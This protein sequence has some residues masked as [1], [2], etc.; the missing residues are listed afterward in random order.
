MLI[1]VLM[2]SLTVCISAAGC[3]V[4][5]TSKSGIQSEI[6]DLETVRMSAINC[7]VESNIE[8]LILK[9][10][11][12]KSSW[13]QALVLGSDNRFTYNDVDKEA[14]EIFLSS[15]TRGSNYIIKNVGCYQTGNS[16]GL[17]YFTAWVKLIGFIDFVAR[18]EG[19]TI[20]IVKMTSEDFFNREF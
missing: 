19:G 18:K 13:D 14:K 17:F 9:G 12:S 7:G 1:R 16:T 8:Q 11:I 6:W 10:S 4:N 20:A 15:W 5:E 2:L 3:T